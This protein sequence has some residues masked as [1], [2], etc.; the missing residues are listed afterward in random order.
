ML[1]IVIP[2]LDAAGSLPACL[3]ALRLRARGTG[4]A[5]AAETDGTEVVVADGGSRDGTPAV[6]RAFG[7]RV[8]PCP[9]GRGA[10]LA[11][12]AKAARGGWLLFLHADTALG[13]GWRQAAGAFVA[14]PANE[15]RAA[16]FRFA[17]GDAS[18][19]ARRI[20][21]LVHWRCQTFRLPYGDQGLLVS[22]AAYERAGGFSDMPLMEDVDIVRRIGRGRIVILDVPAVTSAER[23]RKGGFLAR[24]LLNL[25]CLGLYFLGLPPRLIAR[26]YG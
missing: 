26:L 6:A 23:Y 9:P 13:P 8:I 2:T 22:R 3:E 4:Q 14:D 18:A 12:G 5:T 16:A 25:A 19:A 15:R 7:A 10:Q 21:A 17:L 11:A 24:P 20:E 1:S